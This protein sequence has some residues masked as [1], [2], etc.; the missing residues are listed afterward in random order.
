MTS[1]NSALAEQINCETPELSPSQMKRVLR[2]YR[3]AGKSIYIEA[4]PGVGKS[5]IVGEIAKEFGYLMVDRRASGWAPD[6]AAG[7][8]MQDV[9]T[10][11][12]IWYPPEWLQIK[13][14]EAK[15]Y[16]FDEFSAAHDMVRKPLFGFFL[17]RRLNEIKVGEDDLLVA[18]G[19]IG[20][21][22]T[23][24]QHMDNATRG[25]F[26]NFRLVASLDQWIP[27]FAAIYNVHPAVVAYL[28]H[29]VGHFCM[30]EYALKH[31]LIAYGNP[32]NWTS[33]SDLIW[34]VLRQTG[35]KMTT[36]AREELLWGGS[37]IVGTALA[38]GCLAIYDQVESGHTLLDLLEATPAKRAGMWPESTGQMHAL[39]F[40]MMSWPKTIEQARQVLDLAREFPQNSLLPFQD[41]TSPL[42]EVL[43]QKLR[44]SGV[45][46]EEITR[47]F[48]D[49][50]ASGLE[51]LIRSGR[52][53]I[54]LRNAA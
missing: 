53:L 38:V 29:N 30:T 7:T 1:N 25:R 46:S 36:E 18:A 42:R 16:F 26:M 52:P 48:G 39:L 23:I 27:D 22:G 45:S 33:F 47:N 24:V 37:S 44:M 14:D 5:F 50:A 6:T 20:S 51:P 41:M 28:K 12:T 10:R 17:E 2:R 15:L 49:D 21:Y 31:N 32:R 34:E 19:N 9:E 40:S 8:L 4:E 35:G 3:N 54:N 11:S 13:S 43:L